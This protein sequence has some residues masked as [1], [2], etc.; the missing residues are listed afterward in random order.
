MTLNLRNLRQRLCFGVAGIAPRSGAG[1]CGAAG[2][3]L[4]FTVAGTAVHR[5]AQAGP[6]SITGDTSTA[7]STSQGDGS[8]PGSITVDAA[9]SITLSTGVPLTIDSD[10]DVTVNGTITHDATDNA[11]AIQILTN[12]ASGNPR[13]L[14]SGFTLGGVVS[15]TG[16]SDSNLDTAPGNNKGIY[17]SGAGTFAGSFS[18]ASGSSI[19]V[20]GNNSYGVL[21]ESAINGD[22]FLGGG[23]ATNGAASPGAFFLGPISGNVGFAGNVSAAGLDSQG[24]VFGPIGGSFTLTGSIAT[25]SRATFD[26]NG[27]IVDPLQGGT[28]LR[29][30]GGVGAG[31]LL[32]GNGLTESEELTTL[33]A[34]GAP[35]DTLLYT[36]AGNN[37]TLA[38][39]APLGGG[40]SLI[41]QI[42]AAVDPNQSALL[43]R[44]QIQS[45]TS[46]P[47]RATSAVVIKGSDSGQPL[48]TVRFAGAIR[49]EKGDI[50]SAAV[51]ATARGIDIGDRV[52]ATEFINAGDVLVRA[53]D[54][55]EDGQTGEPG[56]G[57]GDAYGLILSSGASMNSVVNSGNFQVD[58]RGRTFSAYGLVDNS[59]T[60]SSFTNTGNFDA[61][62]R[63]T[64]TGTATAVDLSK[65]TQQI[66]FYNSGRISGAVRLGSGNDLFASNGGSIV[67]N[68]DFGG[69]NN[70]VILDNAV[71]TGN[72]DM[73]AGNHD[74]TVRNAVTLSGGIGRGAG[75]LALAITDSTVNVPRAK[76]LSATRAI[77]TG[78]STLDFAIDGT[79][80]VGPLFNA[81]DSLVIDPTVQIS[82]RLAGVVREDTTLTL[83]S[84][85]NLVMGV[86][87]EAI[88]AST[89]S[90]I[91]DLKFRAAPDN[92]NAVLVDIDRK[93]AAELGL[94]AN[95]GTVYENS[96]DA[97]AGDADLFAAIAAKSTREEFEDA[98]LQLAPDSGDAS[99]VAALNTQNMAHG[100]I[101]RRLDGIVRTIGPNRGSEYSSFWV[102][103]LGAYGKR[104]STPDHDGF[105][106]YAA[107]I[108]TGAD[109]QTTD[110]LK[111]GGSLTRVWSLPDEA[112]GRD[113]P[114]RITT[115]QA[116]FYGRHKNGR[117]YTQVIAGFGYDSYLS[118]RQVVVDD[119]QRIPNGK[120][121]GYHFGGSIDTGTTMQVSPNFRL[122][123]Y[124][125]AAYLKTHEKGYTES[126]GGA[127]VDL[128]YDARNLD[129]LRAGIGIV[130]TRRFNLFQD[131]GFEV[132]FRGDYAR[133]LMA[134]PAKV[135]ARFVSSGVDFTTFGASP[136]KNI[137][138]VGVSLGL[139]DI[140]TAFS[141]D[142][143]AEYTGDYLG[144]TVAA[145]F[146]FRF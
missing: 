130:A 76:V 67:G 24:A 11:T 49:I 106:M 22:V 32:E 17:F 120:W 145:T 104:D 38:I 140:F 79:A 114:L 136:D 139:R 8:G 109:Y 2:L 25:G 10:N 15:V 72:L 30:N 126:G 61:L 77:V 21:A 116:D 122:T 58:A 36:E 75:T 48:G 89:Q 83:I 74:V 33:P 96:L 13:T 84:S 47:G 5:D 113:R 115:T 1:L 119:V 29:F 85:N 133:E 141:I 18:L 102:Q 37:A 111:L 64:S 90:Y 117:N 3:G 123:P 44:G 91:Y 9:G 27:R 70:S 134:D 132:E 59:G 50:Q 101:R 128:D 125:R 12:D 99:R 16:P 55:N 143:D 121:S 127:G 82:A 52:I 138:D 80:N 108:A 142:Y 57:G 103:Q 60:I 14:T 98:M 4:I 131:N 20:G 93:T 62:I 112:S 45:T 46:E 110:N 118:R 23:I 28:A 86:P 135:T 95:L 105:S 40:E 146:R 19:A 81:T 54:D 34:D 137:F 68:I 56:I 97:L 35:A 94:G 69:G 41:G 87:I 71:V 31:I 144:H 42:G 129:S 39:G 43:M 100:V 26:N 6:L 92:P 107:G 124:A 63:P 73:G 7:V 53:Q 65:S 66:T 88:T 78:N 51:N